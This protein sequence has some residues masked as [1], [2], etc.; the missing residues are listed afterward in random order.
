MGF[1]GCAGGDYG[2]EM[3]VVLCLGEEDCVVG[4]AVEEGA[5]CEVDVYCVCGWCVVGCAP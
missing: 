1:E 3:R 4:C 2:A 5:V